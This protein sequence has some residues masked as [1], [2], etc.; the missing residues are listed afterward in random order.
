MIPGAAGFQVIWLPGGAV[1]TS[2]R[3]K[4]KAQVLMAKLAVWAE[5][6]WVL[7]AQLWIVPPAVLSFLLAARTIRIVLQFF[8]RGM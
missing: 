8:R 2:K 1:L 7:W 6:N 4:I 3:A 5:C